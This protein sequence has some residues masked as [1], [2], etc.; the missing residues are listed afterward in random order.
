[1]FKGKKKKEKK[2]TGLKKGGK[3]ILP[4]GGK[5]NLFPGGK[6]KRKGGRGRKRELWADTNRV[7]GFQDTVKGKGGLA[8]ISQVIRKFWK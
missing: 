5:F 8:Q 2:K 3:K 7:C 6:L 1:M 4:G